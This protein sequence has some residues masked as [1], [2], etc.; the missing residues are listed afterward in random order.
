MAPEASL[1]SDGSGISAELRAQL[2]LA[3][4]LA[5]G[6]LGSQLLGLVD[7][8]MLGRYSEAALAGAG[9]GNALLWTITM[10]GM[11]VI[12]GLDSLLPRAAGGGD[13]R[14]ARALLRRG[15]ELGLLLGLPLT[16]LAALSPAFMS[17]FGVTAEAR[18]EGTLYVFGRLPQLIPVLLFTA[19]RSYLQAYSFARPLV[20]T[21][22]VANLLNVATNGVL[23]FGDRG[24]EAVG[25]PSIGL[26]ELGALGAAVSTTIVSW[27]TA[28]LLYLAARRGAPEP[29]P[30]EAPSVETE[31]PTI[32]SIVRLGW[33]VGVQMFAELGIFA[34]VGTLAGRLGTVPAAAHTLTLSLIAFAYNAIVGISAA[35]SV[36]VG[37]ALGRDAPED[38][39]RAG[40]LGL[41]LGV[42]L[43]IPVGLLYLLIPELLARLM[44]DQPAVIAAAV[45]LF[46]V[47][48]MFQIGDALQAIGSGALRGAGDTRWPMWAHLS[49][50][51]LLGLAVAL[52]AAFYLEMGAVGLW[53]GLAIAMTLAG[54]IIVLRFVRVMRA[55][56]TS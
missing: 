14:R 1:R 19:S 49:A 26:P 11:G 23:I 33:P 13:H 5:L 7:T 27:A 37:L 42:A 25:L 2:K 56:M 45:P 30:A 36:R 55:R 39:R 41:G 24:L 54:A 21:M 38:A 9:V 10:F 34:L 46:Y 28:G 20:V 31:A 29:V 12:M 44:T 32:A 50:D 17:L 3:L 51:Y 15:Y 53:W 40:F 35:T 47:A 18:G 16:L 52:Y 43:M 4:P 6:Q 8:A 48:A 22:V